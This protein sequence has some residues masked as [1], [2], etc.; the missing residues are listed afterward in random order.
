MGA[1]RAYAPAPKLCACSSVV[2]QSER[3]MWTDLTRWSC[4]L[5]ARLVELGR[6]VLAG[7]R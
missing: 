5:E 4:R 7:T 3:T 1:R 2:D 6:V